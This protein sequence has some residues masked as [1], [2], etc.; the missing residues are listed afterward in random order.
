MGNPEPAVTPH[1]AEHRSPYRRLRPG[2]GRKHEEVLANQRARLLAAT[3][4]LVAEQGFAD[5]K[6]SHIVQMAG[7]SKASF[8]EQFAGKDECFTAV[9]DTALRAA[10]SA[11]LRGESCGGEG[12]GRLRA[13]LT[14]LAELM[15]AQ[16]KVTKLVLIDGIASTPEIR[17]HLCERFGLFEA[18]V[19]NRVVGSGPA[20]VPRHLTAGLVS[21]ITHHARRCVG[22]GHP[23]RFRELVDP[24]LDWGLGINWE[25]ASAAW[26][27][28]SRSTRGTVL[29]E[30][31]NGDHD[32]APAPTATKDLLMAG[33]MRLA[34]REGFAA[35]T[36]SRI[37]IDAGVSRPSFDANFDDAAGCFLAAVETELG[38]LFAGSLRQGRAQASWVERTRGMFDRLASSLAGAPDL[39][40]LAFTE[41]LEAGPTSLA[42]RERLIT[43][44]AGTI[45][46]DAP[47]GSRPAP[48][49]GEAA[50][51]AIWGY[52]GDLVAV[53]RLHLLPAQA[54]RLAFFALTPTRG[55]E[56]ASEADH[57]A[58]TAG[59]PEP[60]LH[61]SHAP[62]PRI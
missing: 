28:P 8:Y 55:V 31:P 56:D 35:L 27:P 33:A 41:T 16:P 58:E 50:V 36:P 23:E 4:E 12:R 22:A 59:I 24:L 18:L 54:G 52:L 45:Y 17:A 51:A 29:L 20:E 53:G 25:E 11:V 42:W 57:D 32:S 49:A 3:I 37:R 34:S 5:T 39:A 6:V 7:V 14:A 60:I 9:C 19:R 21:G 13:G 2:P 40:R 44:W 26:R 38:V 43:T 30:T 62:F 47:G 46:H 15:V 48:A 1:P 61:L 10:A